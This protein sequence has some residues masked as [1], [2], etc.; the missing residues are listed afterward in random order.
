M[1]IAN[2][3]DDDPLIE[4][5]SFIVR[6]DSNGQKIWEK[7]LSG[8]GQQYLSK[9]ITLR[10]NNFLI[11]GIDGP[12]ASHFLMKIDI[13]GNVIWKKHITASQVIL[14]PAIQNMYESIDGS[15]YIQTSYADI[16]LGGI[17][18]T[19]CNA[20]GDVVFSKLIQLQSLI[21]PLK[22]S[23]LTGDNNYSYG[24]GS[25][26]NGNTL[27]LNGLF[28]KINNAN[29]D[30]VWFKL[31]DFNSSSQSFLQV[32]MYPAN[33]LCLLG[34][35]NSNGTD[36][37]N[38]Y[39]TDTAGQVITANYFQSGE[40]I[41]YGNAALDN[42]GNLVWGFVRQSY[43]ADISIMKT[44]P[45]SG[46]VWSKKYPLLGNGTSVTK[47]LLN[48][49]GTFYATGYSRPNKGFQFIG[50]FNS[51]GETDCGTD[52]L[53]ISTSTGTASIFTFNYPQLTK[54]FQ[55]ISGPLPTSSN[56][57]S[58]LDTICFNPPLCDTI[59]IS[60]IDTLCSLKDTLSLSIYRNPLCPNLPEF[61]FDS[62]FFS[63]LYYGNDS[64]FFR[65]LKQGRSTIYSGIRDACNTLIDSIY[66][67]IL[68][69]AGNLNLGSDTTLCPNNSRILDAP[70][71]YISYLWQDGSI[72][73]KYTVNAPG[74]YWLEVQDA[75]GNIFRDSIITSSKECLDGFYVPSAFTPNND[76]KNDGFKPLLFGR[77]VSYRL[78]IYN[79]WGQKVFESTELGKGWKGIL[80][81]SK[82]STDIFVWQ[83]FYQFEAREPSYRKGTVTLIR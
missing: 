26:F 83:C 35:N 64:A 45:L 28:Y 69:I 42:S 1:G 80:T 66:I 74:I 11:S 21:F 38:I 39:I 24:V 78:I 46:L 33:R 50:K 62:T 72:E 27:K 4:F 22:L 20:L 7:S 9:I 58:M 81:N 67:N 47:I 19:K 71:G 32:F 54:T 53:Q 15:I 44:N 55:T 51:N 16:T 13:D 52:T 79:R 68:P 37:K 3:L 82:Q 73:S 65:P 5:E 29:G 6:L 57:I 56:F 76:G 63:L 48:N 8:P 10:D 34:E 49:T 14:N 2:Y 60:G 40:R 77:V 75:C 59:K 61:T 41:T 30:I 31:Y 25:Y 23:D 12:L 36:L 17:L 18:F 70:R 43:S